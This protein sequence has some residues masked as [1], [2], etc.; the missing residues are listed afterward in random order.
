MNNIRVTIGNT[1]YTSYVVS[2]LKMGNLLDERLDEVNLTLRYISKPYFE[3]QTLV[4]IYI[5]NNPEAHYNAA[6]AADILKESDYNFSNGVSSDGHLKQKLDSSRIKQT[7]TKYFIVASDNASEIIPGSGKFEH[8]I[9]L[10]ERTKLL[11]GFIGDSLTFTNPNAKIYGGVQYATF[12]SAG[13]IGGIS[14]GD[15]IY[16]SS[17]YKNPSEQMIIQGVQDF[18]KNVC[19]AYS[20]RPGLKTDYEPAQR[21]DAG[22]VAD[23]SKNPVLQKVTVSKNGV[24]FYTQEIFLSSSSSYPSGYKFTKRTVLNGTETT[25]EFNP[26][27]SGGNYTI[28]NIEQTTIPAEAGTYTIEYKFVLANKDYTTIYNT[29]T[30]YISANIGASIA[31]GKYAPKKWTVSSVVE[32]IFDTLEPNRETNRFSFD[33]TQKAKYDKILAPEFTFTKMTVREMLRTVGGFIHAEPRLKD[34]TYSNV[35][36]FDEYGGNEKSHISKKSYVSY[37]LKSDINEWCTA[38][39]S[40]AEN[41]VNQLGFASGTSYEPARSISNVLT[42]ITLRTENVSAQ[43]S[44]NNTTFAPTSLPIYKIYK[45]LVNIP[46]KT[47]TY[48]ITSY[49]YEQADYDGLLQSNGGTYPFSKAC[50][51]YYTQGEKNIKGLFYKEEDSIS[52]ILKEYSI[53]NIIRAVSGDDTISISGIDLY[54]IGFQIQYTP[55]YST[56]IK[57]IKPTIT[58]SKTP[59]TIA[60][61]QGEN[62]IETRY[63]GENL[64][65]VIA[66]LGNIE[67]TYTYHLAFLSD[68]PKVGTLFDDNYYISSVYTEI[69][70]S[71]IKCTVGLS[72]DFNRLSQYVG[73][74]SNKRMWEVSEKQSQQRQ[75]LYTE[76]LKVSM[77]DTAESDSGTAFLP[78]AI[79]TIGQTFKNNTVC[80]ARAKTKDKSK[81]Q[82]ADITLPVCASAFGNS[83][84]F[85]FEFSDNYSAGQQTKEYST[86][87]TISVWGEYVPY[88]DYFGRFYYIDI[89]LAV[90]VNSNWHGSTV[91]KTPNGLSYYPYI[92]IKDM[93][94]RKDNREIPQI[95]YELSAYSDDEEILVG[96]AIMNNCPLVNN[97]P[98]KLVAYGFPERLNKISSEIDITS[99]IKI[100]TYITPIFNQKNTLITFTLPLSKE[101]EDCK[102]F[103]ILTE[104]SEK[105]INVSDDDGNE[106]TQ[107]IK[108][109][110][111]LYIGINKEYNRIK[112]NNTIYLSIRKEI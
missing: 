9:Y 48:D 54:H 3:P 24:E 46:N 91:P 88:C 21:I 83:L 17:F 23:I 108:S 15:K 92:S 70:Q 38:L 2:P 59:R 72:K 4:E 8:E 53:V 6:M 110:G 111:L 56:R 44:Q 62:L 73:I 43:L 63:Y 82:I 40:S 35:V 18:Y 93:L 28:I 79:F 71:V 76:Y 20:D 77:K 101:V 22:L 95:S 104:P 52:P 64:K 32:R 100:G 13:Y 109:G 80:F 75:S 37:Q 97:E 11:E 98:L 89:D 26:I 42:D 50:A 1:D 58:S 61:N 16:N 66:R 34:D 47:E 84:V 55:I 49:V 7:Y 90:S 25:E 60:Y 86:T 39:D 33:E 19:D 107:T 96:S 74:S 10:I 36:L 102:S 68:I 45:V 81:K 5:T 103:A 78:T 30:T 27:P 99:G 85:T 65:G 106:T 105:V 29:S 112:D 31:K 69:L 94:Y 87:G 67:K 14:I 41:L 57:T 12:L 51:I